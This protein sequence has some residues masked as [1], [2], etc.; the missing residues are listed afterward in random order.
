MIIRGPLGCGKS[1][2]AAF[3]AKMIGAEHLSIDQIL[4]EGGLKCDW[5]EG[6][7]SQKS[8]K[9]ANTLAAV[10]ANV[11]LDKKKPVVF[12]GNFY[13]RSQMEDLL[14]K[15]KVQPY[16]FT[17]KASLATCIKRDSARTPPHGVDAATAVYQK[18]M[19]FEYGIGIDV[20][21]NSAQQAANEILKYLPKPL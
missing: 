11:A 13:W 4:D 16:V 8:F 3:V 5:E 18:T 10:R 2:V 21:K 20:E 12:D 6:Y 15:I 7:I 1:T 19:S 9:E 17:L 14:N